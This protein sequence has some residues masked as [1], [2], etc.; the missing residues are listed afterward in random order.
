MRTVHLHGA[1]G[2]AFGETFDFEIDTAAEAVRGLNCAFPGKFLKALE[3]GS[4][5][6]VMGNPDTGM[7]LDLE[8]A[9]GLRL[10]KSDLHFIPV[11]EGAISQSAKGTTKLVLGAALVGAAIFAS[12]GTL[13]APLASSGL[14][15][16]AT[17]GNIALVGVGLALAGVSTLLTKAP[18]QTGGSNDVSVAGAAQGETGQQGS[19]IP[20]IYGRVLTPGITVSVASQVEDISVYA[21]S[22][23]SIEQAFG[24]NPA[25]WGGEA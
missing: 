9:T 20:L 12:G 24:D 14:L 19:A 25:Y 17:W 22:A 18:E 8:L 10:G 23:G 5:R 3:H 6:I 11:A 2:E 4:Y 13:A 16:G 7:E 1:L 21:N 15:S